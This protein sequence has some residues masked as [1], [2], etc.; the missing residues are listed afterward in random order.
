[1]TTLTFDIETLPKELDET[2]KAL[3][4]HKVRNVA[5]D[6][7]EEEKKR[8][9]FR[10]PVFSKACAISCV[11][12]SGIPGK[13]PKEHTFFDRGDEKSIIQG[14]FATITNFKGKFV[15][16]NTLDF[17]VPYLLY[18]C[19]EYGIEPNQR[20]C[21]MTRFRTDPHYDIMQ[22]LT[23]WGRYPLS[24]AEACVSFGV[25]NSKD[26]LGGLDTLTFM[27]QATDEQI[28]FYNMEDTR[29]EK[30]IYDKVSKIFQ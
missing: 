29:S 18:K 3:L 21:N 15:G 22:M 24:L 11:F 14:F 25:K 12:D 9:M 4:N 13:E 19:A 17:D 5:E 2:Y 30:Q 26:T 1:M 16:F 23:S 7:K 27:L 6:L 8:W 20:F 28:I 10:S